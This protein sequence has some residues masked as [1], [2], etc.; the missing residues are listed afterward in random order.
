[1]AIVVAIILFAAAAVVFGI[2]AT[3]I[4]RESH[5]LDTLSPR[6]TYVLDDAVDYVADHIP[7]DSQARLTHDEVR[8]L[9]VLHMAQMRRYGLQPPKAVDHVQDVGEVVV[10]E[11]NAAGYLMGKAD[12]AGIDVTDI[13]V[14]HVVDAHLAYFD[15]IGAVGPPADGE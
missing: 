6:A 13:D 1:M 11:T 4:G 2:A 3:V 7:P 9:L 15:S 12:E 8:Q 14:V 10:D 5:R